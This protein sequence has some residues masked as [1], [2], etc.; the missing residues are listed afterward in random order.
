MLSFFL[1][2]SR[3][4]F[5][6]PPSCGRRNISLPLVQAGFVVELERLSLGLDNTVFRRDVAAGWG[7]SSLHLCNRASFADLADAS[8]ICSPFPKTLGQKTP[9]N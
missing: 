2:F 6:S 4:Q 5:P 9:L 8:F 1:D 7:L 3:L